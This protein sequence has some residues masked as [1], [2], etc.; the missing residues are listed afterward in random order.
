MIFKEFPS[1][2]QEIITL[3]TDLSTIVFFELYKLPLKHINRIFDTIS[4]K[5]DFKDVFGSNLCASL[6]RI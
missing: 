6:K 2:S 4:D 1:I 3:V 5:L